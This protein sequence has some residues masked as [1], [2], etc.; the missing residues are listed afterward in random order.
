MN[1]LQRAITDMKRE[2]TKAQQD[3]SA[4]RKR[5]GAIVSEEIL[6]DL[7]G[8]VEQLLCSLQP[9][10]E[11]I[12]RRDQVIAAMERT[13]S[14]EALQKALKDLLGA[15]IPDDVL[16]HTADQ[17]LSVE[18]KIFGSAASGLNF[19]ASADIDFSLVGAADCLAQYAGRTRGV[20]TVQERSHSRAI[21]LAAYVLSASPEFA[22][23]DIILTSRVPIVKCVHVE[24]GLACDVASGNS[25]ALK[26]TQ[27]LRTY[28]LIDPRVRPLMYAVKYW[29]KK[30]GICD[31]SLG[32]LSSYAWT[33]LVIFFLQQTR[34]HPFIIFARKKSK[35]RNKDHRDDHDDDDDLMDG[36]D[37]VTLLKTYSRPLFPVLPCLQ[38]E[39]VRMKLRKE[40]TVM[41][42][43][44][45]DT[46]YASEMPKGFSPGANTQGVGELL[47]HFFI[48]YAY[49]FDIERTVVSIRLG[50]PELR[51]NLENY[52][53]ANWRLAIEDPFELQHDLGSKIAGKDSMECIRNELRRAAKL[54]AM[55]PQRAHMSLCD[56]AVMQIPGQIPA[57]PRRCF[58]CGSGQHRS[59]KCPL[60]AIR[61]RGSKVCHMC[62]ESGHLIRNCPLSR[63]NRER[64][65]TQGGDAFGR[66]DGGR[67]SG[68]GNGR[69]G[70]A[71]RHSGDN[72]GNGNWRNGSVHRG[73]VMSS[74]K[75][76]RR[77]QHGQRGSGRDEGNQH[78]EHDRGHGPKSHGRGKGGSRRNEDDGDL[79]SRGKSTP[80][81]TG[82][83][84]KKEGGKSP[85]E[86]KSRTSS[87]SKKQQHSKND[88]P[89]NESPRGSNLKEA[90]S[91]KGSEA[92]KV[93]KKK[94]TTSN[95]RNNNNKSDDGNKKKS[96]KSARGK[97][98]PEKT[99]RESDVKLT[100][101]VSE[102]L[103][104]GSSRPRNPKPS[105]A[106]T[107]ANSTTNES[108]PSDDNHSVETNEDG[109]KNAKGP[110]QKSQRVCRDWIAG[111]CRFGDRCKFQHVEKD[112]HPPGF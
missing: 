52:S 24:T 6:A 85:R 72:H 90:S 47:L 80:K 50:K 96:G 71:N 39:A 29:A 92:S 102:L 15:E 1:R 38:A 67:S 93:S 88:P 69:G 12:A 94:A 95:D 32:T 7:D 98:A 42:G 13:L 81:D 16:V 58:N 62:G 74:P 64:R 103:E 100:V 79:E 82:R 87:A 31:A 109:S 33:L 46:T 66:G 73:D 89:I 106:R 63:K 111:S 51:K 5:A 78:H 17:S 104:K 59:A 43:V 97:P 54:L 10:P 77:K 2:R 84:A 55:R 21:A 11:D 14:P 75:D 57:F 18:V 27:L 25:I 110:K 37:E 41:N 40:M 26:N 105:K 53:Q 48:F 101:E 56:A 65:G 34:Q 107:G 45:Y 44:E 76:S 99:S 83:S 68:R 86:E 108:K 91:L 61:M 60:G 70:D 22:I 9:L 28:S 8:G 112:N 30:R 4:D 36:K 20:D 3:A 19:R 35:K 23:K 49:V